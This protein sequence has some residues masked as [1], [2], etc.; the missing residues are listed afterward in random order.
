MAMH[1]RRFIETG[2]VSLL[3]AGLLN[4]LIILDAYDTAVGRKV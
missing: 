4:V 2:S 3:S 1:R